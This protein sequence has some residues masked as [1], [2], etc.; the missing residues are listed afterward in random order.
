M[1]LSIMGMEVKYHREQCRYLRNL[2]LV[3]VSQQRPDE[4]SHLAMT[5]RMGVI[6]AR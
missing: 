5:R 2:G 4:F 1:N 3:G 6:K